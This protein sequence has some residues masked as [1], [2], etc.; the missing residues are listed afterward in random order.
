MPWNTKF[1]RFAQPGDIRPILIPVGSLPIG[2]IHF[3][4]DWLLSEG[5]A[6]VREMQPKGK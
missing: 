1:V 5:R 4:K 3:F 2:C 6:M